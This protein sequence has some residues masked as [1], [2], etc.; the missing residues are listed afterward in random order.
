M[1]TY[2]IIDSTNRQ[3]GKS[4]FTVFHTTP[5]LISHL[6][7]MCKKKFNKTRKQYMND[8]S[9]LGFGDDDADGQSFFE[10]MEQYFDMGVIRGDSV[11]IKCNIFQ[12]RQFSRG[13]KE[14]GN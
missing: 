11:P 5:T 7:G 2:Y 3:N 14:H 12:A 8:A 10:Q 13:K 4:A 6:E 9:A 1:A